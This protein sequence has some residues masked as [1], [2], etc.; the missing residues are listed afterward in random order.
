[1]LGTASLRSARV[2][3]LRGAAPGWRAALGCRVSSG[4]APFGARAFS[5]SPDRRQQGAGGAA[6]GQQVPREPWVHPD[7]QVAGEA[8]KK[9]GKVRIWWAAG[10]PAALSGAEAWLCS[11]SPTRCGWAGADGLCGAYDADAQD[12]T[13]EARDG[14]LDPVIGRDEE[15]RRT[16]QV[17]SRRTKVRSAPCGGRAW[18]AAD[19]CLTAALAEQPGP[20]RGAGGGENRHCGGSGPA[21]RVRAR[22]GEYEAEAGGVAGL[23]R[24]RRRRQVPRRV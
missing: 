2:A 24:P 9:Y 14:K 17:I 18:Q 19:A 10:P 12:L 3:A 8:L 6:G 4:P 5:Y 23:V 16:L 11:M 22:T 20:H 1:M 7:A 21:D 13:A 15:V